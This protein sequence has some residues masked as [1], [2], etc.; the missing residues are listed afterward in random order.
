MPRERAKLSVDPGHVPDWWPAVFHRRQGSARTVLLRQLKK[1][2]RALSEGE[3][4]ANAGAYAGPE[5]RHAIETLVESGVVRRFVRHEPYVT[6]FAVR[7]KMVDRTYYE[8]VE[9]T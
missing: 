6:A 9:G 8:L 7:S 1:A 5:I 2:G 3:I 4:R